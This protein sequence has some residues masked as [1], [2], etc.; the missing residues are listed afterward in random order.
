MRVDYLNNSR[1]IWCRV[2]NK[3][4]INYCWISMNPHT[5]EA[6]IVDPA[7]DFIKINRLLSQ[8]N[9]TLKGVLLTHHHH[10]H[11][12][13]AR[14]CAFYHDTDIYI[15]EEESRYYGYTGERIKT[16]NSTQSFT[17]AGLSIIPIPT[18]GHTLGSVCYW[19]DQAL[20]TGDTLFNEGCG[21]CYGRG[22]DPGNMYHSM[23]RLKYL[24]DDETRVYPGHR[25]SSELGQTFGHLKRVNIYLNMKN[26]EQ[27]VTFRMRESNRS[28]AF[29][30]V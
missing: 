15:S 26:E 30:F 27:F 5:R 8:A 18:P 2:S 23:Q 20:F 16:F 25:F 1:V 14:T 6:I 29:Q 22:A 3:G 13:L 21:L 9:A 12:D 17:L 10:D 19:I 28:N 24:V 4:Y 11:V 7:W